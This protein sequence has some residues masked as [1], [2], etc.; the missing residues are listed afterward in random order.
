MLGRRTF[1]VGTGTALTLSIVDRY[2]NF[3]E[4]NEIPLLENPRRTDQTLYAL[5]NEIYGGF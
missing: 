3:L 2:R 5:P 1:L 4:N